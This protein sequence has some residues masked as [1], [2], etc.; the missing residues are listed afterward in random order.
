M[1]FPIY[2]ILHKDAL[3]IINERKEDSDMTIEEK[4]KTIS[5]IS[6]IT[7]TKKHEIIFNIIR[8]HDL[9]NKSIDIFKI[10]YQGE[11]VQ[12]TNIKF[13][14]MINIFGILL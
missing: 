6:S 13:Y 11:K 2:D 4:T 8:R 14:Q 1:S 12:E 10:P 9:K 5:L 3:K 7:D